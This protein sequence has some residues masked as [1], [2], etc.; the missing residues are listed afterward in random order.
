MML[1]MCCVV[2]V[3][4]KKKKE[5]KDPEDDNELSNM[6]SLIGSIIDAFQAATHAVLSPHMPR[7]TMNLFFDSQR[8]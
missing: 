4:T 2:V 8:Q 1:I 6:L 3:A 7:G 5:E